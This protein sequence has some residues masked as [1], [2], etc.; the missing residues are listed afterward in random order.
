MK[1]NTVKT[2][3]L[4]NYD[5]FT[6]IPKVADVKAEI[7]GTEYR[8][9]IKKGEIT[10]ILADR[11]P[12]WTPQDDID[13]MKF[14]DDLVHPVAEQKVTAVVE[15][16]KPKKTTKKTTK[17]VVDDK[18]IDFLQEKA[19]ESEFLREGDEIRFRV[20]RSHGKPVCAHVDLYTDGEKVATAGVHHRIG[21]ATRGV[22]D[23]WTSRVEAA[24]KEIY[25]K[26]GDGRI[27]KKDG[28]TVKVENDVIQDAEGPIS[29][30]LGIIENL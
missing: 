16:E 1:A 19:N 4:S 2:E 11:K 22:D 8:V 17:V 26:I 28:A 21:F 25:R 6:S 29:A 24:I 10:R 15:D 5:V 13:A 18:W 12:I 23:R 3:I 14:I 7:K 9:R 20:A 30:V 27:I